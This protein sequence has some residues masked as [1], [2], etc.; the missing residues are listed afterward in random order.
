MSELVMP[1]HDVDPDTGLVLVA[2]QFHLHM[3]GDDIKAGTNY[4]SGAIIKMYQD[5]RAQVITAPTVPAEM[6]TSWGTQLTDD[7]AQDPQLADIIEDD[8]DNPP[9]DLDAY[10][11]GENNFRYT[12]LAGMCH[13]NPYN[14]QMVIPGFCTPLGLIKIDVRVATADAEKAVYLQLNYTKGFDKGVATLP[15]RQ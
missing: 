6:S 7:G 11:G 15:M 10:V 13:L 14:P 5:T 4:S 3:L 1:E 9:Y 8:S 2:D 12:V